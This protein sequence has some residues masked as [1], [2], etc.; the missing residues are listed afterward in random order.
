[1]FTILFAS[2]LCRSG[3][4][5]QA[6]DTL[7][8]VSYNLLNYPGTTSG[9][10]NPEYRKIMFGLNPDLLVVQE[11][12]SIAA[13]SEFHTNVMNVVAPG[14]FTYVGFHNGPDTDNGLYFRTDKWIFI[15]TTYITTAL[16]DIAE[17]VVRPIN[18]SETL[19]VFSM[20]LKA[21]SGSANEQSRLAEVTILRNYLSNLAA[22]TNFIIVGD[23]NIYSGAEPAWQ[24]LIGSEA[25]NI[26]QST[27]PINMPASTWNN[28]AYAQY[29]TQSPRVRA[30]GG[31]STGG[32]DDRFDIILT[33]SSMSGRVVAGTYKPYGNDGNHYNDSINR[34]P[35]AAVPDSIANA[36]HNASDHIPITARFVFPRSALPVQLA[37][38][39]ATLNSIHDSV[40]VAWTTISETNNYGFEVQRKSSGGEFETIANSF[41]F[42]HGTTLQTHHYSFSEQTPAGES[43]QY[44]LKQIDLDGTIS[45]SDPVFLQTPTAVANQ[46]MPGS[47]SLAQNY[48]NP[49]NPSTT[50]DFSVPTTSTV[51]IMVYDV[52]GQT[53]AA[54]YNSIAESG[55]LHSIQFDGKNT[56]GTQLSSGVYFYR[57]VTPTGTSAMKRMVLMR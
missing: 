8:V 44:R 14:L 37:N 26:G 12:T 34:L 16:R 21:S 23:Y 7:R 35:N 27:D 57:L 5:A 55:T 18:S 33:S 10:R 9:I 40:V 54:L 11:M 3:A 31:G 48:P 47:F 42:G 30:F 4:T 25:N 19:H 56:Q 20:H 28:A 41:V 36:L 1:V 29:H 50:I 43:I 22:G 17:Y 45:Y 32:M 39:R 13:M 52:L 49:F 51:S 53:V 2:L 46:L 6:Y 24:K 38:L 15:D